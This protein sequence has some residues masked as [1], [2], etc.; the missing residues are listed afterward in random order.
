[1]SIREEVIELFKSYD[2]ENS[3]REQF[4]AHLCDV[5]NK[6]LKKKLTKD[7]VLLS[8]SGCNRSIDE[9]LKHLIGRTALEDRK[10]GVQIGF[11]VK[12]EFPHFFSENAPHKRSGNC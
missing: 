5:L 8:V 4:S 10:H 12:N 1:M 2:K 7:Q 3:D 11:L 6:G 9:F